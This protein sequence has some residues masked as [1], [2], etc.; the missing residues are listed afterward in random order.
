MSKQ[1]RPPCR[2]PYA[3][4]NRSPNVP[5]PPNILTT[6]HRSAHC[7]TSF[8]TL[9]A[10]AGRDAYIVRGNDDASPNVIPP[11][12]TTPIR[13]GSPIQMPNPS[14]NAPFHLL[15][16]FPVLPTQTSPVLDI[17]TAAKSPNMSAHD[18]AFAITNGSARHPEI[19]KEMDEYSKTATNKVIKYTNTRWNL[20][21]RMKNTLEF[22]PNLG[23]LM[24]IDPNTDPNDK[25]PREMF[26]TVLKGEKTEDKKIILNQAM[27]LIVLLWKKKDDDEYE[28]NSWVT[29]TSGLFG[30][31][32]EYGIEFDVK[33]FNY[34]GGW[35]TVLMQKLNDFAKKDGTRTYGS[36]PTKGHLDPNFHKKIYDSPQ[37]DCFKNSDYFTHMLLFKLGESYLLRGCSEHRNLTFPMFENGTLMADEIPVEDYDECK[38]YVGR[39]WLKLNYTTLRKTQRI[40]RRMPWFEKEAMNNRI[41]ANPSDKYCVVKLFDAYRELCHPDQV[42]VYCRIATMRQKAEYNVKYGRDILYTPNKPV[43]VHSLGVYMKVLGGIAGFDCWLTVHNHLLRERGITELVNNKNVPNQVA[44]NVAQHRSFGSQKPYARGSVSTQIQTSIALGKH[45]RQEIIEEVQEKKSRPWGLG[46]IFSWFKSCVIS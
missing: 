20:W 41:F 16:N 29:M 42:A 46:R 43:G 13:F 6:Q 12:F 30:F 38:D 45:P 11:S 9:A 10:K 44:L 37:L 39:K 14:Y 31:F 1:N 34:M 22:D 40:T 5:P 28:P 21:K 4:Q 3:P 15:P 23:H 19:D 2:N 17:P 33:E 35:N 8:T 7:H 18:I 27:R 36:K 32:C 24:E 25:I 26:F